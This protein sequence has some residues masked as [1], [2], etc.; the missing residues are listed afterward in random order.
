MNSNE[1]KLYKKIVAFIEVYNFFSSNFFH[2]KSS[3][4]QIIDILFISKI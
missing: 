2:L 4:A 1:D 3:S